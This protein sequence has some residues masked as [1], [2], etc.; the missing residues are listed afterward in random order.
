[1]LLK[2][3][4][5]QAKTVPFVFLTR[6][7]YKET[8]ENSIRIGRFYDTFFEIYKLIGLMHGERIGKLINRE[9]KEFNNITFQ[10]EYSR[11]LFNWVIN[12]IGYRIVSVRQTFVE[13]I[14]QLVFEAFE[15]GLT[16]RDLANHIEKI[17]NKRNFY[18]WQALRI[19][20]TETGL[21]ANRGAIEAGRNSGVVLEKVWISALDER[22]RRWPQDAFDHAVMNEV[23]VDQ[24]DY[25][26]VQGEFL[27][28][29]SAATTRDGAQS[30]AA[31]VIN[32]RCTTALIPKRDGNGKIIRI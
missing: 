29:P 28:Y 4:K 19:A 25:F 9:I 27:E 23:R 22:T 17:I 31:N 14:Q 24:D 15:Q 13:Y 11:G 7:N 2:M 18:R 8:I 16:T 3:F 26:N 30:S 1:M 21:A 12:N 10:G 6:E 20:R 5:K 32:C